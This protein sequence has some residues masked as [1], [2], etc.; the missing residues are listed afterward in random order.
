VKTT[1][2]IDDAVLRD[3][4]VLAA[5]TDRTMTGLV[6]EAVADLVRRSKQARASRAF[7]LVTFK[8]RGRKAGVDIDDTSAL[9]DLTSRN[10]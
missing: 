4:K 2:H 5:R 8:G 10:R 6:E 3:L 1:L 7:R 9:L